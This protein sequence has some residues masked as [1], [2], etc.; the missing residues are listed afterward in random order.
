MAFTVINGS[1]PV[2]PGVQAYNMIASGNITKGQGVYLAGD[3]KVKVPV[4]SGQKLFGISDG[5]V[6]DGD[7]VS[8]YGPL[9]LVQAKLSGS[10]DAGT[11]VGL[12]ADGYLANSTYVKYETGAMVT[13]GVGSTGNGEVIILGCTSL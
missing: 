10:V 1:I 4:D 9:N 7:V 11:L 2:Q 3:D 6:S 5:T 8:I 12:H 13:K